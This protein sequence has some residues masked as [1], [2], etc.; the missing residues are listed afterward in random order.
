MKWDISE[1]RFASVSKRVLE[2]T[3]SN[4]MSLICMKKDVQ[5]KNIFKR[6]QRQK[7]SRKWPIIEN[8]ILSALL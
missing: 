2:R 3:H 1:L 8:K 5:V 6:T 4:E 7:V